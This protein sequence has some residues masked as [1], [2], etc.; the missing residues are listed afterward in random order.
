[1]KTYL[2]YPMVR[3]VVTALMLFV[4]ASLTVPSISEAAPSLPSRNSAP[5]SIP[6]EPAAGSSTAQ[7][8]SWASAQQEAMQSV[9]PSSLLTDSSGC[10]NTSANL[11]PV[12]SAGAD[13]IPVGIV[14]DALELTGTCS[15]N[16]MS[17]AATTNSPTSSGITPLIS[18]YCPNMNNCNYGSA[19][20]GYVAVGT[21]TVGGNSSYMAAAYTYT[22]S[23]SFTA[24][25]ELGTVSSGCSAGTA[26]ANS[27]SET[28]T[29]NTY[30]EIVWGPRNYSAN[31]SGTGW[32]Y[33]GS[34]YV[35]L[36][37]VCGTW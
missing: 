6:A 32:H 8:Q 31:W 27:N 14:T 21:T 33:N 18:S 11:I 5:L 12:V 15:V 29:T 9:D 2:K 16:S 26:V 35:D 25:A 17:N 20:N 7:W 28:L 4:G 37:S 19:T 3:N 1:M 10:T 34:S 24:H 36:G 30:V 13:G 22:G 23:G